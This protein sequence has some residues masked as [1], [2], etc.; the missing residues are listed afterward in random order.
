MAAP[1]VYSSGTPIL[2]SLVGTELVEVDNGG[3]VMVVA[4]VSAFLAPS[5][6]KGTFVANGATAVVVANTAVTANSQVF[7][8]LKTIGGTP[9]G[10]PFLSAV[11]P[12][13][14]F[15]VKA[16]AGDTST[17]NYTIVG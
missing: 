2:T 9:A 14:G 10:A 12:G 11:T 15:S 13:T 7:F 16:A 1:K 5:T 3:P 17:Y 8:T 6:S 4:P